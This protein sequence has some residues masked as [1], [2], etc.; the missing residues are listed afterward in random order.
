VAVEVVKSDRIKCSLIFLLQQGWGDGRSVDIYTDRASRRKT[1]RAPIQAL[2][3]SI[4]AQPAVV[5]RE[6]QD[7]TIGPERWSGR[8]AQV[9]F[10]GF[11]AERP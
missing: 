8:K 9:G 1:T 11:L 5:K 3:Q 7:R 6:Q 2:A 4:P 10:A